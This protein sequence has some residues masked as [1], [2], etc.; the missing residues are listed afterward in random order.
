MYK[1]YMMNDMQWGTI[2][3]SHIQESIDLHLKFI[4]EC[5]REPKTNDSKALEWFI[6]K[7]QECDIV[8]LNLNQIDHKTEI[9]L[10]AIRTMNTIRSKKIFVIGFGIEQK[11]LW[12]LNPFVTDTL[13]HTEPTLEEATD[14]ISSYLLI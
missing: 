6:D 2:A 8:L 4:S 3:K 7:I 10:M 13:F 9:K 1:V 14:Y 5:V 12:K 11:L